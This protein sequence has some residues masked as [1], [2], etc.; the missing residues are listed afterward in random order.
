[1]ISQIEE[2]ATAENGI[3][4]AIFGRVQFGTI[5]RFY[6]KVGD[7]SATFRPEIIAEFLDRIE[8]Y[9]ANNP[10]LFKSQIKSGLSTG[11]TD[12]SQI[13]EKAPPLGT[14][15]ETVRNIPGGTL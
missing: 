3:Y 10:T 1:M 9:K 6:L 14:S 15:T 12:T 2:I 8:A 4:S 5:E 7:Q 13:G 11:K